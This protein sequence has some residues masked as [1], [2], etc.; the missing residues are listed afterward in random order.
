MGPSLR[1]SEPDGAGTGKAVRR[2]RR[3]LERLQLV[4]LRVDPGVPRVEEVKGRAS[5]GAWQEAW[6][7]RRWRAFLLIGGVGVQ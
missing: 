6:Q 2:A 3:R 1:S 4:R 5:R 7:G